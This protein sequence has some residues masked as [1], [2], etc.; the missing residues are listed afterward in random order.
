M[1]PFLCSLSL[2]LSLS[3]SISS[4]RQGILKNLDQYTNQGW[5]EKAGIKD[6]AKS[7]PAPAAEAAAEE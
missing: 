5:K 7:A 3:L 4:F 1:L 6:A 2:S